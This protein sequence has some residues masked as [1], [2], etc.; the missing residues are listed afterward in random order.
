MRYTVDIYRGNTK[1]S[2][3]E[4]YVTIKMLTQLFCIVLTVLSIYLYKLVLNKLFNYCK[5]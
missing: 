1:T 5:Q 2:F 3:S 4:V